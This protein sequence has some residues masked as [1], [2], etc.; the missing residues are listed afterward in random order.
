MFSENLVTKINSLECRDKINKKLQDAKIDILIISINLSRITNS[1]IFT[2]SE[3]N[4]ADQLIQC[5]LIWENKFSVKSI[6][7]DKVWFERIIHEIEIVSFNDSMSRFSKEI[8]LYNNVTF[9]RE[10]I[11]LTRI[12]KRENKTHSS[13]KISFK[14]KNDV[15][16][17]MK[18]E[19]TV[20][21]KTLQVTEF[22][23]NRIN[24]CHKC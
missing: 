9:V 8:E 5:W 19:L 14:C 16:K 15:E 11:W 23:N 1:I 22:L 3:K 2:V 10:S 20:D 12:E 24:Q 13:M 6:Q 17:T 7:E 21:E 18:K 4:T